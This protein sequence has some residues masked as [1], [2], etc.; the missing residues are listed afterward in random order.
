MSDVMAIVGK[1]VIHEG[2]GAMAIIDRW[3]LWNKGSGIWNGIGR[4]LMSH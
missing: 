2:I 3:A 4:G 1:A